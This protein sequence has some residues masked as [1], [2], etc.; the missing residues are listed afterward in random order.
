MTTER[1]STAI[2]NFENTNQMVERYTRLCRAYVK[3]SERFHQLDV[4]HM[5]L[6]GNMVTLLKALKA[7]KK[8]TLD[9]GQANLELNQTLS[10]LES[11]HQAELQNLVSTYEGELES[12]RS[13]ITQL[14]SLEMF[15]TPEAQ[16]ELAE[17]ERQIDLVEETLQEMDQDSSP[18]LTDEEKGLLA[19]Y[20]ANPREF[21]S[22]APMPAV[23]LV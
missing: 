18:D 8:K 23:S 22:G 20:Y 16:Q 17:A 13:Q 11:Q 6:K 7:Y 9:L 3:L 12:L 19:E 5:Q 2:K 10:N 15:T 4:E 14:H 1:L 21:E